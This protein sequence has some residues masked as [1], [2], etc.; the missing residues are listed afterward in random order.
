M[1][2]ICLLSGQT[3]NK[4]DQEQQRKQTQARI[5]RKTHRLKFKNFTEKTPLMKHNLQSNL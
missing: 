1:Y 3:T 2:Q 5:V 4:Y